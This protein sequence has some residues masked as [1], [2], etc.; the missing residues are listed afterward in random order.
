LQVYEV[1]PSIE[2]VPTRIYLYLTYLKKAVSNPV[3][4]ELYWPGSL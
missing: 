2:Y 4:S 1:H 3:T